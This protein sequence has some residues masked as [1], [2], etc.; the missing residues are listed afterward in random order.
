[1]SPSNSSAVLPRT[2]APPDE[3]NLEAGRAATS[4][5]V[6]ARAGGLDAIIGCD[7]LILV[8]GAAGFMGP[9]VVDNLL[10]RGFR[11]IRC[12]SRPSGDASKIDAL[13]PG[14]ENARVEIVRGNLLSRPDCE[15]VCE[16]VKVIYHLAA[17]RGEKLVADAFMNSV[18]T[19]RNLLDAARANGCLKRFV[20]ISS[21]AVYSNCGK[22]SRLLDESCPVE[23]KPQRRGDAYS[24]AKAKQDELLIE[25]G[26]KYGLPYVI[27]RPGFVYGPGNESISGRVGIGTFGI[28]LHLGGGNKIPLTYVDNCAEAIVL[29]GLKP[30]VDGE[31]F[32]VMDDDLPSSRRFLSLYKKNVKRFRSIYVPHAVSFLLCWLWE[33]YSDWSEGQLPRSFNRATWHN[34]W[35]STKYTNAKLKT[36]LGWK[37]KVSTADALDRYFE[38]C[39]RKVKNG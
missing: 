8:T 2:A 23:T 9:R 19:T 16:G 37:P 6:G 31:V 38:S 10:A 13:L 39:R 1:M 18:V 21:F 11:N 14:R 7:D 25:Y 26:K 34:N 33:S 5:T 3:N 20:G 22:P 29:A 12:L 24:F 17:G 15:R 30:G 35:K 4:S 32:N 27:V 36:R 28:F